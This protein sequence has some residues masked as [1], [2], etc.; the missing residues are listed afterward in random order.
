VRRKRVANIIVLLAVALVALIGVQLYWVSTAFKL[1]EADFHQKVMDGLAKTAKA[2]EEDNLCFETFSKVKINPYQGLYIT[3]QK[4]DSASQA[5]LPQKDTVNTFWFYSRDTSLENYPSMKFENPVTAEILIKYQFESVNGRLWRKQPGEYSFEGMTGRNFRERFT[6]NIPIYERIDTSH[7]DSILHH[8]LPGI[9]KGQ[10]LHY[11]IVNAQTKEVEYS[12][13]VSIRSKLQ[14]SELSVTLFSDKYFNM[15]YKLAV[16][17]PNQ[18][19]MVLGALWG[20]LLTSVAIIVLLIYAFWYF[21]RMMLRQKKLS[22]MKTDFI[23]NMTHEFKTPVTNISLALETIG[24]TAHQLNGLSPFIKIIGEENER[25]RENVERIL[26]I[27]TVDRESLH[28]KL[29]TLDLHSLIHKVVRSFEMQLE[30]SCGRMECDL[31]ATYANVVGD[32]THIINIL[33]NLLDNAIKY[34]GGCPE[35][36]I[37]TNSNKIGVLLSVED[38][39]IGMNATTQKRIFDKFY[40]A[41]TGN[42]HDVKGFGLGLSYVKSI[43]D[44]HK[45][46]IEVKSEPGKGSR[47]DVFLPFNFTLS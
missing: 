42:V 34:S 32:E 44:A 9:E 11:G 35:V 24:E 37:S 23:N 18:S 43:I 36:R 19:G 31:K 38:R 16:Y 22:E 15:P 7:L 12:K 6:G 45:G 47:F 26:Q 13:G 10:K 5:W 1:R 33:Y 39:G 4:W 25:L 40:R 20:M 46:S 21:V 14:K 28:L 2:V 41:Q 17:Y 3:R 30:S 8:F 29:E 27:A